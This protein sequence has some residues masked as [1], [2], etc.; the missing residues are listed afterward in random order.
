MPCFSKGDG[1]YALG[2]YQFDSRYDLQEFLRFC[3]ETNPTLYAPFSNF[4]SVSKSKLRN[5]KNLE[6]AWHQ[7]YEAKNLNASDKAPSSFAEPEDG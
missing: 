3:Y 7:V 2:Y 4:L 1:Y 5:N 6:K